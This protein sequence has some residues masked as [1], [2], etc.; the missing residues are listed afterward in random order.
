EVLAAR[1]LHQEHQL[2]PAAVQLIAEGRIA[3]VDG[4]LYFDDTVLYEPIQLGG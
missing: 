3:L 1:V 2:Y 4:R